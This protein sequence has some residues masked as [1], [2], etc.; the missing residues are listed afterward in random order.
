MLA[1]RDVLD[2]HIGIPEE[3]RLALS[4][5][6][7]HLNPAR[8]GRLQHIASHRIASHN[9]SNVQVLRFHVIEIVALIEHFSLSGG[10]VVVDPAAVGNHELLYISQFFK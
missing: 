6:P 9:S 10:E 8:I 3:I 1:F 2:R 5:E 4:M 7:M